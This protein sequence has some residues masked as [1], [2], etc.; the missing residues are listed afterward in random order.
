MMLQDSVVVITGGG[1]GIG[2][3]MA[4]RF[5][6]EGA[7]AIVVADRDADAARSV[8]DEI[9]GIA[10]TVD[11]TREDDLRELVS[12]T[13]QRCGPI[14]L[15]CSNAGA[16]AHGGPEVEDEAW[17]R[18]WRVNVM[19]HVHAAR[20]L[21]P[22]MVARGQGHF[23]QTA[24][25]AGLLSQFDAPY[26][27]SKHAAVAFA[28]WL[29]ITYGERGIGVSCLCPLGVDTP[30]LRAEDMQ[31][32]ALMSPGLLSPDDVAAAVVQGLAENRFLILPHPEVL[33]YLQR[34]TADPER[35]LLGMRR[36]H[37]QVGP[38]WP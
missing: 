17:E 16:T 33:A 26:A 38:S 34:K 8:A 18:V 30:M 1:S 5:A 2:A 25:A 10:L 14:D 13:R 32:Q 15:F 28:E 9:G 22:D 19:A 12:Q 37:A 35:W 23:L 36:L 24:S 21:L 20:A 29:S 27:V 4:R 3:A 11:V 6:R 7:R 31:R